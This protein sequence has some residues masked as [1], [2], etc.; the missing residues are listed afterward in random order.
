M[1]AAGAAAFE[2]QL[3]AEHATLVSAGRQLLGNQNIQP[4]PSA[5]AA[6][7]AGQVD[8]R[9][10]ANLSV[11]AHQMPVQVLA[12]DG[13]PPGTSGGLPLRGAEISAAP[14]AQSGILAFLRAQQG[15]YRPAVMSMTSTADGRPAVILRF[16]VPDPLNLSQ[17]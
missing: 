14:A 1:A 8:F 11:L 6:L 17:S 15:S 4:S 7:Q 2:A 12:F 16:D 10:L 13:A 5:R 9:L 3:A